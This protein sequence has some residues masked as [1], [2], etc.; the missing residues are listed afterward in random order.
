M[1]NPLLDSTQAYRLPDFHSFEPQHVI[2]AITELLNR[3]KEGMSRWTDSGQPAS[4]AMVEDEIDWSDDLG[5]AW[6]IVSH[7]HLVSDSAQLREVYNEGLQMLTEHENWRQHH[8]GIYRLYKALLDSPEF[9]SLSPVQQRVIRLEVK[10]FELEGVALPEKEQA[11]YRKLVMSLRKQGAKFGQNL[12]DARH[13]WSLH[14]DDPGRLEGLSEAGLAMLAGLAREHGKE[15]WMVDLSYPSYNAIMT[16]A[17]DRELRQELYHAFVTCASD[18]GPNGGRWD[19]SK[20]IDGILRSRHQLAELLGFDNYVDYAL[21]RRMAESADVVMS[22]LDGLT[23]QAVPAAREQFARLEAFAEQEG[24]VLP[25]KPWDTAYWSERYRHARLDLSDEVLKPYFPLKNMLDAVFFTADRVFGIQMVEDPSVTGWHEDVRYFWLQDK[26]GE[27]IGGLFMDLFARKN[28]RDGAWMDGCLSRR[29]LKTGIQLPVAYLVCNFA[30]PTEDQPCLMTHHDVETLFHEFGHCLHH[31]LTVIEWPQLNGINNVEWDA[32]ELPSQ[33]LENWCWEDE[34]MVRFAAHYQTGEELP[35]ELKDRLLR[36]RRFLKA[37]ALVR[38]LE[39]AIT[40]MRLHLEYDPG[41]PASPL[42]V[43]TE[44]RQNVAVME[45]PEWNRFLN[46]FS[47]IFGGGYSAGYYS[48]LWA[49]QLAADAWHRFK[50]EGAF[51][52]EIG[53]SLRREI[54]QVGASRPAMES[55][56]AFRGRPP[57]PKPLLESYG[58]DQF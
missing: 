16:H 37:L 48:Y 41:Q 35:E 15:G 44:V 54:L 21:S 10:D 26:A 30:A 46:G 24:A 6:S 55:F 56:I 32:V 12:L 39:F 51:N 45:I 2:P 27:R 20:V 31:L 13:A 11:R 42:D 40:D 8:Q 52:A 3:Y 25:L 53:Q 43:L 17:D 18:Q 5:R 57:D 29:Q 14:F 33:L 50:V 23:E 58:L 1:Q 34:I 4:W 22:F 9:E 7:L 36:S 38:Q 47:H 49:E 28:K 19:N